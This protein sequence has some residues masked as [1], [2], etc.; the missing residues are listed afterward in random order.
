[1]PHYQSYWRTAILITIESRMPVV[2]ANG[3]TSFIK[4]KA[5]KNDQ[6]KSMTLGLYRLC[7]DQTT[8]FPFIFIKL[9]TLRQ[10]TV[11][12]KSERDAIS[13]PNQH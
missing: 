1:M 11:P 12:I 4:R 7:P 2:L 9:S 8:Y 3:R 10:R 5:A 13:V 6:T